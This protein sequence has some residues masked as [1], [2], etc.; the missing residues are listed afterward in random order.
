M[1]PEVKAE[2]P[3]TPTT[4]PPVRRALAEA[5]VTS[6][7]RKDLLDEPLEQLVRELATP[8]GASA[9]AAR[10]VDSSP[11]MAALAHVWRDDSTRVYG[12]APSASGLYATGE[13]AALA[14]SPM[15]R[16]PP[17]A[18]L[19]NPPALSAARIAA[20][21]AA[22]LPRPVAAPAPPEAWDQS[23]VTVPLPPGGMPPAAVAPPDV[24]DQGGLTVPL[25][26]G[27]SQ[28]AS[29][30]PPQAWDQ[31]GQTVALPPGANQ[32]AAPTAEEEVWVFEDAG[33]GGSPAPTMTP[34][35]QPS[36]RKKKKRSRSVRPVPPTL[37][38]VALM[39]AIVALVCAIL[40][41]YWM[42]TRAAQDSSTGP[43]AS[44]TTHLA[45]GSPRAADERFVQ[46][47]AVLTPGSRR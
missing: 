25:P 36:G 9:T 40:L 18:V 1:G 39:M 11:D 33:Q 41:V 44:V 15:P 19:G 29:V 34:T 30:A 38:T 17:P 43:N 4:P 47:S 6:A 45:E 10:P 46:S 28:V 31:G 23:G 7:V 2:A 22:S 24:W 16:R 27:A 37:L 35:V 21:H 20:E 12:G 5:N 13:L 26:P 32:P 3:L 8:G 14:P 42:R